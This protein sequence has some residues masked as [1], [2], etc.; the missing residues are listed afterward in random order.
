MAK[1]KE[2]AIV[3]TALDQWGWSVDIDN[4]GNMMIQSDVQEIEGLRETDDY[5]TCGVYHKCGV[6]FH[7]YDVAYQHY[8]GLEVYEEYTKVFSDTCFHVMKSGVGLL[9]AGGF[10]TYL[11]GIIGGVQRALGADK[12]LGVVFMDGHADIETPEMTHSHIV[13]G[14][15]AAAMLGLGLDRWREIAGMTAPIES[16]HF[17]MTDY[18]AR[19]AADDYNIRRAGLHI[20]DENQF[21]DIGLWD[22]RIQALAE[23]V[24]AIFLHIDVDIMASKYVPAFKFPLPESGQ[25]PEMVIRNAKKVMETGKVAGLS[26]MDVCFTPGAEGSE[27]TYL[28]AMRILGSCLDSWKEIP[29][30]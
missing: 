1:L 8:D 29:F 19:S 9:I 14:M 15:P 30:I 21:K 5:H 4:Q 13:A 2:L 12:K 11:P 28:N 17:V 18:H 6:P 20:I 10:C 3:E 7:I 27:I 24:D 16:D 25:T 26:I 22:K 23:K